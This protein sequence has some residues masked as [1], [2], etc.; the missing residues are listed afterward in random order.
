MKGYRTLLLNGVIGLL[1]VIVGYNWSGSLPVELVWIGP[2]IVAA[3][4]FALR[5]ITNTPVGQQ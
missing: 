3:A 1:T 2:L 5:F 4:N